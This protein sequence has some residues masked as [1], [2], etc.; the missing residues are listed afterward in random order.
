VPAPYYIYIASGIA[1][2]YLYE[3]WSGS[4]ALEYK[5][6]AERIMVYVKGTGTISFFTPDSLGIAKF[7]N[8]EPVY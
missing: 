7:E 2:V 8:G 6:I 3:G 4:K 5:R 1:H